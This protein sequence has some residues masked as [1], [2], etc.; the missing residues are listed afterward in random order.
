MSPKVE[1]FAALVT[2]TIRIVLEPLVARLTFAEGALAALRQGAGELGA[3]R[4]R[5]AVL[6][7]K[8]PIPG[9]AGQPGTDGTNGFGF[10]DLSVEFDGARTLTLRFVQTSPAGDRVKSFP[11]TLPYPRYLGP[12]EHGREYGTGDVVFFARGSWHCDTATTGIPG[13]D[14]AWALMVKPGRDGK[15]AGRLEKLRA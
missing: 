15:D 14:P 9:P 10:D 12:F 3:V 7:T 5:L 13:Q 8:A 2:Q 11:L 4:E 6:E 1:A